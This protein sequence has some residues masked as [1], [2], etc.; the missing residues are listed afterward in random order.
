MSSSEQFIPVID[1]SEWFGGGEAGRAK[2]ARDIGRACATIGFFVVKGHGVP[3][4]VIEN[5]WKITGEC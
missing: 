2:V 5:A 3:P 4:K 1:M